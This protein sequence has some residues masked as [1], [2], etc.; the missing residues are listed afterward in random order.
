MS[1]IETVFM[2]ASTTTMKAIM[3]DKTKE[4]FI[5][6]TKGTDIDLSGA[7]TRNDIQR[8]IDDF[9]TPHRK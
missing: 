7:T 9:R 2:G 6:M 4:K 8:I 3:Q 5:E 1:N